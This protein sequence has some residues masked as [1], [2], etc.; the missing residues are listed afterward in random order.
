MS[1]FKVAPAGYAP[2]QAFKVENPP[3]VLRQRLSEGVCRLKK[4]R[5]YEVTF[6]HQANAALSFLILLLSM[7]RWK[8]LGRVLP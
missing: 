3:V 6:H 5:A 2:R 1:I 7:Q 4:D 8:Y